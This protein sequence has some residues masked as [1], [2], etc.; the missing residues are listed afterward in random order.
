MSRK[1]LVVLMV[2]VPLIAAGRNLFQAKLS[3]EKKILHALNRL[4]FGPRPGDVERVRRAGIKPWVD[5]QLHPE[6]IPQNPALEAKLKPLESIRMSA[7]EMAESYP[8]PQVIR[9]VAEGRGPMPSDPEKRKNLEQLAER[10]KARRQ[11]AQGTPTERRP[12]QQ[13][14]AGLS[15][16]Q[17]R[18]LRAGT[19]EER[20]DMF[21]R[22]PADRQS[23]LI[24]VMPQ[25]DRRAVMARAPTELRRKLIASTVPQ[26][27]IA[28]DLLEAKLYRAVY[29]S[30][31]LEE[32]LVD[33][34]YNHFNVYLDKGA[35]RYLVTSYERDAI[36]PHVLGKFHELA[37]ATAEHP[38]MLFYLDNWQSVDPN[39]AARLG[40]RKAQPKNLR[41]L[42]ENYARELLELHTLGVD[43][44]YTQKDVVE[45]ARCFTGWTI[46]DPR[47]GAGFYFNSQMHDPGEKTVLG[48]KIPGGGGV[49]DGLKVLDI[50]A[51]HPS[52]A[53]FVSR[54][55]AQR[56][57][58]DDPPASLVD[59][60]AKTFT[61]T[62]GDLREVMRTMLVSPEFFSQGAWRAKVK[63]P[64][65]MVASA[66]RALDAEVSFAYGLANQI[67]QLGQPL[68]RKEEPT[69]YYDTSEEWVSTTSLLNRMNFAQALAAGTMPGVKAEV[70]RLGDDP[71]KIARTLLLVEPSAQT[72]AAIE[73][74]LVESEKTTPNLALVAGLVLGSPDFQRR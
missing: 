7:R 66:V 38:A 37:R 41:G 43:G 25:D 18:A 8:P 22:L 6:R 3:Q 14:L 49:E 69:G 48:V 45:V 42:N 9:A 67:A 33:F 74:A 27:L 4:T 1:A 56:F 71:G 70:A 53:R 29:S 44:G 20:I 52:T 73:K 34:W 2:A 39:A 65:E 68:Y 5:Q 51:S 62:G 26:E 36:R 61:R 47:G 55:L 21:F 60:M 10:F 46:R 57:V 40:R 50:V 64:L 19:P 31:Q 54:K 30:R 63:S 59:K 23:A 17:Q 58:A 12:F 11:M 16:Q 32:V 24:E 15:L 72:R 13:A 28:H 35:D